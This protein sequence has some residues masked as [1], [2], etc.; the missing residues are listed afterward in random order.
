[1]LHFLEGIAEEPKS[2]RI[3]DSNKIT[4]QDSADNNIV[5]NTT[6]PSEE[7]APINSN[8]LLPPLECRQSVEGNDSVE[9][10]VMMSIESLIDGSRPSSSSK[11][12]ANPHD[13]SV[14]IVA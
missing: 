4:R 11:G 8:V 5:R 3:K 7:S 6:P 9:M 1:M 13:C 10:E 12:G 2:S 14:I